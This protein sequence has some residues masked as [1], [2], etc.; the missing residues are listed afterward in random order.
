[1]NANAGGD[2]AANEHPS[3]IGMVN[4]ILLADNRNPAIRDY[5]DP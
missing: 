3:P 5:A 1:M 2:N 4:S